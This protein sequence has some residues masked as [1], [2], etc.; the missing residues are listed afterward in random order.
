VWNF[1]FLKIKQGHKATQPENSSY[2]LLSLQYESENLQNKDMRIL[3]NVPWRRVQ[4]VKEFKFYLA[5][6]R[7]K[8]FALS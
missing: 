4:A 8:I 5:R 6:S 1:E 7:I 2:L 3:F